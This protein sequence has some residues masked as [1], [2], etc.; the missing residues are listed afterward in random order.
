MNVTEVFYERIASVLDTMPLPNT[1]DTAL[2]RMLVE[3]IS[4]R[5]NDIRILLRYDS[6][7]SVSDFSHY[8]KTVEQ[9]LSQEFG[10]YKVSVLPT[11]SSQSSQ[12]NDSPSPDKKRSP[13]GATPVLLISSGKGGV[14]K[15]SIA[16]TMAHCLALWGHRI[17]L[18]DADIYGPS[19]PVFLAEHGYTPEIP[20]TEFQTYTSHDGNLTS[21]S[22]GFYVGTHEALV[23][24]GP[25][26]TKALDQIIFA[27]RWPQADLVIIDLPPGTGD[28]MIS[29]A[30]T[31]PITG[32][33]A[34]TTPHP[35]SLADV[36]RSLAMMQA[37]HIPTLG[38]I[39]NMHR[40]TNPSEGIKQLAH[41]FHTEV[42]HTIAYLEN[43]SDLKAHIK[44]LAQHIKQTYIRPDH[45]IMHPCRQALA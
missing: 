41:N 10:D 35:L 12:Q 40:T 45:A 4:C 22:M 1:S 15:S 13:F 30:K 14:G 19:L 20:F 23:W 39:G 36:N 38:L 28:V 34:V 7:C 37:L 31:L 8:C 29:L 2:K 5:N 24:R 6:C 3:G 16:Y 21:S 18:I 26:L 33:F 27:H 44:P 42:L 43:P 25:M 17:H 32:A 11:M 9:A